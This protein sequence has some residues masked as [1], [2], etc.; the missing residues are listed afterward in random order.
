MVSAIVTKSKVPWPRFVPLVAWVIIVLWLTLTPSPLQVSGLLGWD[1]LQHAGAFSVLALLAGWAF[2]PLG[3]TPMPGW[4][5]GALFAFFF[6]GL[7]E[8]LQEVFTTTRS[9]E[10]QDLLADLV[11]AGVV[12]L[13]AR[14]WHRR[15]AGD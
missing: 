10:W 15:Q 3:P 9:A 5:R 4:F 11:G 8:L 14:Y 12:Y 1:K 7:V 6:G 2:A 13:A